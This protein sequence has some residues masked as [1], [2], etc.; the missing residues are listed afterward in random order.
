ME[1]IRFFNRLKRLFM[2]ER[3]KKQPAGTS[4][5]GDVQSTCREGDRTR[6]REGGET[7]VTDRYSRDLT[8]LAAQGK[9]DP[10]VGREQEVGRVVQILSRRTKNNPAL[11]GEPGVGKTAVAEGLAFRIAS[12]TVPEPLQGIRSI[13]PEAAWEPR[14]P[15]VPSL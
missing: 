13:M 8:Q 12:G 6:T 9:L 11:I 4:G 5:K 1:R 15:P 7:R 14:F 2:A 10:L 3:E